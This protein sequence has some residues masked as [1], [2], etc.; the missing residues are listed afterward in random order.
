MKEAKWLSESVKSRVFMALKNARAQ[1]S[2]VDMHVLLVRV[3]RR[4]GT[5]GM[6]ARVVIYMYH[7]QPVNTTF[8]NST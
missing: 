2:I 3:I 8:R 7:K 5:G 6:R 4:A 1:R